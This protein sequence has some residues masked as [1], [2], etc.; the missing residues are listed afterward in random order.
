MKCIMS[1]KG[2]KNTQVG[3]IKR[4]DD[5]DADSEV[6]S[7]YWKYIPKS[8]YKKLKNVEKSSKK[9]NTDNDVEIEKK[10]SIKK[11]TKTKPK[12]KSSKN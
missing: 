9:I 6:K 10:S 3:V 11:N 8:E 4:V 7:G 2:T 5:K 12:Q 1:V